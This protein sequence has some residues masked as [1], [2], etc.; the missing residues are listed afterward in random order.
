[1][2]VPDTRGGAVSMSLV[3]R[4]K[5][6]P[7]EGPADDGDDRFRL[8]RFLTVARDGAVSSALYWLQAALALHGIALND[9]FFGSGCA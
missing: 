6:A 9:P 4:R 3:K 7:V 2:V 5:R 8:T 1:M